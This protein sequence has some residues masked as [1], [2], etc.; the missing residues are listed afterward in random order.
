MIELTRNLQQMKIGRYI[1]DVPVLPFIEDTLPLAEAF[2]RALMG[3]YKRVKLADKY[4]RNTPENPERFASEVFSGKDAAGRPLAG[5]GHAYY[6]PSDEDGDGRIDHLTVVAAK[7][8]GEDEIRALDR[9]RQVRLGAGE[10]LLMKAPVA[11]SSICMRWM[12]V[13]LNCQ[14]KLAK[15]FSSAKRASQRRRAVL[16]WR[17][18]PA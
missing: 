15:V 13:A 11:R 3:C 4:G 7:G 12:A 6:L 14:S 10:P 17:R 8:L 18:R 1:I 5:H 2:R 16:R 9:F